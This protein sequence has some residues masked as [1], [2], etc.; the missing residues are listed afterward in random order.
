MDI[1]NVKMVEVVVW[2]SMGSNDDDGFIHMTMW[3][4]KYFDI[5]ALKC[6]YGTYY[7]LTKYVY[8]YGP[9]FHK[10]GFFFLLS[11]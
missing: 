6:E 8:E 9:V 2:H 3:W 4:V 7:M 5:M 1:E 11:K 10:N